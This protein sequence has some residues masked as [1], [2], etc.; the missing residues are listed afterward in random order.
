MDAG[1]SFYCGNC[2]VGE[3]KQ[4]RRSKVN[5][6]IVVLSIIIDGVS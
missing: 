2:K 5:C 6:V 4:T 1:N 3:D